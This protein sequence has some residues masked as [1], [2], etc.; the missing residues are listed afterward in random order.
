[1][2]NQSELNKAKFYEGLITFI[3]SISLTKKSV[4]FFYFWARTRLVQRALMIMSLIWIVL[5]FYKSVL[6]VELMR[7]NVNI[8]KETAEALLPK[9]QGLQRLLE[10]SFQQYLFTPQSPIISTPT[11]LNI[12]TTTEMPDLEF[13]EEK[14]KASTST[15]NY[16]KENL[17]DFLTIEKIADTEKPYVKQTLKGH[18]WESLNFYHWHTLF[19]NYN[20]SLFNRYVAILPEINLNRL[21][22]HSDIIKFRNKEEIK[23]NN[24]TLV[25]HD[26]EI[27]VSN[28]MRLD[29]KA[30]E[31]NLN[32]RL[33]KA[34][35][36]DNLAKEDNSP[37]KNAIFELVGI[38]ILGIPTIF[39]ILYLLTVFYK[40]LCSKKYEEWRRT[41]STK[42]IKRQYK[43][44][45][46]RPANLNAKYQKC[47]KKNSDYE[48]SDDDNCQE[49]HSCASS[50][51]ETDF[52]SDSDHELYNVIDESKQN[53]QSSVFEKKTNQLDKDIL[54]NKIINGQ[55]DNIDLL[56]IKCFNTENSITK[57]HKFPIDLLTVGSYKLV[58][59]DINNQILIWSLASSMTTDYDLIQKI[60]LNSMNKKCTEKS[61]PSAIW[62]IH[63]SN[64]DRYLFVGQSNGQFRVFDLL[65]N[66]DALTN[67]TYDNLED[68]LSSINNG[69]THIINLKN[70]TSIPISTN[71]SEE[72]MNHRNSEPLYILI[73]RLIGF[74][75]IIRYHQA[76]FSSLFLS[77]VY[78]TPVTKVSYSGNH[79][80]ASSQ[81]YTF[82]IFQL[83]LSLEEITMKLLSTEYVKSEITTICIHESLIAVGTKNGHVYLWNLNYLQFDFC[84]SREKTNDL[85]SRFNQKPI[86]ELKVVK[87]LVIS[88]NEDHQMCIWDRTKGT[89]I[90][91]FTF[92]QPKSSQNSILK[93]LK[94]FGFYNY[95]ASLFSMNQSNELSLTSDFCSQSLPT[96]C[97]YSK[98]LLITGGFSCVFIWNLKNG[99]ELVKKINLI[100]PI[101]LDCF[102][103]KQSRI[104]SQC[105]NQK[106][107]NLFHKYSHKY[108][109]KKIDLVK[110]Q[111]IE[112]RKSSPKRTIEKLL[113]ISDYTDSIYVIKIPL[114]VLKELE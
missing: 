73:V 32:E 16:L 56:P 83:S 29:E 7:H 52:T 70:F 27:F 74:I 40:C 78:D 106:N 10:N 99:G 77:R 67:Q 35:I 63:I 98:N 22:K 54:L 19:H 86:N 79:L 49:L 108:Y 104:Q 101:N 48:D 42:S 97:L 87:N 60:D 64:N 71:L 90:K 37:F 39:F 91:E 62:S 36:K 44:I 20:V 17:Y 110:H 55:K 112:I 68:N 102:Q 61:N 43:K 4:Q 114:N 45:H 75:E 51:H 109:V 111:S 65:D 84:L 72:K 105:K 94:L 12:V 3:T 13:T 76:K 81:D 14:F 47:K 15:I 58:T 46:S 21:V 113:L 1:M 34:H 88:L 30:N 57:F 24:S 100:R 38:V 50:C 33:D 69:I 18:T 6:V 103:S 53:D 9:R 107:N 92:F 80:V 96:M 25:S 26:N 11:K 41:W 66:S 8:S 95:F 2:K 93:S 59:S 28:N 89:L 31:I 23:I 85:N 5:I 82:K